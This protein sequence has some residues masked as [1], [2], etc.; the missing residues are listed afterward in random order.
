MD[1]MSL[2]NTLLI[3]SSATVFLSEYLTRFTKA[4]GKWAQVQSWAVAILIALGASWLN[5]GI[6]N[7]MGFKGALVVGGITGLVSNGIFDISLVQTLLTGVGL[8]K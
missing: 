2:F 4:S 8:K 7:G 5:L 6:F 1:V 3:M